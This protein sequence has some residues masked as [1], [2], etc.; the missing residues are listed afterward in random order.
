MT[1]TLE[2]PRTKHRRATQSRRVFDGVIC[3]GGCDWWYHNRAHYDLQMMRHFARRLPV[4]YVNSIGIRVPTVREGP[5]FARRILRKLRSWSRGFKRIE[6]NFG[7]VSP[8]VIPGRLGMTISKSL[9]GPQ[10]RRAAAKMGIKHPLVWINTPSAIDVLDSLRPIGLIYERTD[11]WEAFP[12]ADARQIAR[13]DATAKRRADVTLFA[14]SLLVDQEAGECRSALYLE[15]GVDFDRFANA[16][17]AN[18]DLADLQ[19]FSRP[20]VGLLGALDEHKIDVPLLNQVAKKLPHIHFILVGECTLPEGWR[21]SSNI[22]LLGK[23]PYEQIPAYMAACDALI[24]PWRANDWIEACNPIKL[25]EYLATGRPVVSTPFNEL[26]RYHG[27]VQI[28]ANADDF[29]AKLRDVLSAPFDAEN[30]RARVAD[31]TWA[32]KHALLM[33]HLKALNIFAAGDEA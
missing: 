18:V 16:G 13:C 11:R 33:S 10:V 25:K 2:I 8:V 31:Q 19:K 23:R 29:A 22:Y 15:H 14:S 26:R 1:A 3:F 5:M 7:V 20:R 30:L 9:L 32:N 17:R 28:A 12:Q 6:K 27:Y 24:M 21:Q 4:L